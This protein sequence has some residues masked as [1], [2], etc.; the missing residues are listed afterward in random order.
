M[1]LLAVISVL[2]ERCVL[3]DF[4]NLKPGGGF[5]EQQATSNMCRSFQEYE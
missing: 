5:I 2:K 4:I 1:F 3:K